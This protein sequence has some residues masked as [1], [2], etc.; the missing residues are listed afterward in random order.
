MGKRT[1]SQE[2]Y[3]FDRKYPVKPSSLTTLI[4]SH[5]S[6]NLSLQVV[7]Y[8][9]IMKAIMYGDTP[10]MPLMVPRLQFG[11]SR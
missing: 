4:I 3:I 5:F 11:L 8:G 7:S 2:I 9:M 10:L 6:Q 1:W